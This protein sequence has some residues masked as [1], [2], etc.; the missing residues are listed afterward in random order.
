MQQIQL[1]ALDMD[2]TTLLPDLTIAEETKQTIERVLLK[3]VAVCICTGRTLSELESE[4]KQL[5]HIPYLITGNGAACWDNQTGEKLFENTIPYENAMDVMSILK[6][7]DMRIEV[8]VDGEIFIQESVYQQLE[9]YG[10]G[11]FVD[12][13]LSTRHTVENIHTFMELLQKPIDKFNLFF[14]SAED[15]Q[16]A[17]DACVAKGYAV[18]SSFLQNMEVNAKTANK[19]VGL[20]QLSKRLKLQQHQVLA[21]GDQLNDISMLT[22]A[23]VP[24]AMG[25]AVTEVKDLAVFVTK[26]NAENG[27]AHA[28]KRYI[29]GEER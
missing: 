5:K 10:A 24:I 2:G 26:S 11:P 14:T 25:N 23:G 8:Y 3:N 6:K 13:I 7:Y 15:R 19:G 4:R 18:T 1:V 27:V 16:E 20:K 29:L 21:I 28:L 9:K 12:Y 17:W 22:F